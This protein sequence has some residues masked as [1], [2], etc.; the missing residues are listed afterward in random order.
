MSAVASEVSGIR[1]ITI[2][3]EGH[4]LLLPNDAVADIVGD[5][6]LEHTPDMPDWMAGVTD[7][8]R[9][10]LF[11]VQFERLLG[12]AQISASQRRRIVVCY[13]LYP[14]SR[15][16]Y[17]GIMGQSIPRLVRISEE[18][19]QGEQVPS[20]HKDAPPVLAALR[21]NGERVL[22]PDLAELGRRL[23]LVD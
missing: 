5:R 11:V 20:M 15:Q 4:T 23:E 6:E 21:F 18:L 1:G 10:K 17:I 16:D 3:L 7:W 22:I 19:I 9:R 13:S 8:Q 2:P 14:E 12:Q